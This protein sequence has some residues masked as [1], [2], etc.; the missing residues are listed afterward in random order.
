[1]A[2]GADDDQVGVDQ[3]RVRDDLVDRVAAQQPA[4]RLDARLLG[5]LEGLLEWLLV[6]LAQVVRHRR[7]HP[8]AAR[9]RDVHRWNDSDERHGGGVRVRRVEPE[10]DSL[11]G[12]GRAVGCDQDGLHGALLS[13]PVG[14][15]SATPRMC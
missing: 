1:V 15:A 2:A 5:E 3:V 9:R 7:G 8:K 13:E 10:L 14:A 4:V 12:R 6:F 11:A